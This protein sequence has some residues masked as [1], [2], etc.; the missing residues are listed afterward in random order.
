[1]TSRSRIHVVT[2]RISDTEY[3]SIKKACSDASVRSLSEFARCAVLERVKTTTRRPEPLLTENLMTL[4]N[5]LSELKLSLKKTSDK[6][7]ELIGC[8][9]HLPVGTITG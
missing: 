1:M 9:D 8:E 2:F 6:I 3:E 7:E 4:S 5:R